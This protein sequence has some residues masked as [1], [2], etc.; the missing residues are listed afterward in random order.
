MGED[1]EI[2]DKCRDAWDK[3][4]VS[5]QTA[6]DKVE[7]KYVE[8]MT[9]IMLEMKAGSKGTDGIIALNSYIRNE[10]ITFPTSAREYRAVSHKT[11]IVPTH[12]LK[13]YYD[14][15]RPTD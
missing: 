7:I 14:P 5:C 13:G 4:N 9:E 11:N 10:L 12:K 6:I 2:Y 3:I 1:Q 15:T 8:A